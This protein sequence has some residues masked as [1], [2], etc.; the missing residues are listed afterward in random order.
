M[1]ELSEPGMVGQY[2]V[3]QWDH[4]LMHVPLSMISAGPDC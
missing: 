1:R 2:C 3:S 4:L